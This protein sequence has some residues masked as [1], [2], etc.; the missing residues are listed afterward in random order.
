MSTIS[1]LCRTVGVGFESL[2]KSQDS[3]VIV[4]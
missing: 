2:S 4:K 3:E 1:R